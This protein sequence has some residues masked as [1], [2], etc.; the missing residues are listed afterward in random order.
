MADPAR[1]PKTSHH[2]KANCLSYPEVLAQSIFVIDPSTVPA[3][4]LGLI[5]VSAGNG[6]WFSFLL[7]TVGLLFVSLSI[8]Q[9]ARRSASPGSLYTCIVKGLGPA[10]GAL[11]GSRF[12]VGCCSYTWECTRIF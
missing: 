4:I 5:F 1:L 3:A 10:A 9:F 7:A 2:L 6:T 12:S 8:N 11:S